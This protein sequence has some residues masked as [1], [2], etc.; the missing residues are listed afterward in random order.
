MSIPPPSSSGHSPAV[1]QPVSP[2]GGSAS[3]RPEFQP[4]LILLLVLVAAVAVWFFFLRP[5]GG[6]DVQTAVRQAATTAFTSHD[7]AECG[8]VFSSAFLDKQFSNSDEEFPVDPV[9]GPDDFAINHVAVTDSTATVA[10]RYSGGEFGTADMEVGMVDD[11]G[12]KVDSV[13]RVS[14][15]PQSVGPLIEAYEKKN[16]AT[17]ES[18]AAARLVS[19]T[20]A[21]LRSP[22]GSATWN[23]PRLPALRPRADPP[24]AL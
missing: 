22:R 6:A 9:P 17:A 3:A 1:S 7:P 19:C 23:T 16:L 5:G 15:Q 2:A 13:K 24:S 11:G 10:G 20:G 8:R 4:R 12:W 21:F 18:P 14:I